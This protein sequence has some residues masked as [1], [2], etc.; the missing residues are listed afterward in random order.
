MTDFFGYDVALCMNV[1]D[2]DDKIITRANEVR[3]FDISTRAATAANGSG[4][5]L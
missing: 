3:W 2:I 5:C 1:T 4:D